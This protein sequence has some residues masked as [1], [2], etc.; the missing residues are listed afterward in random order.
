VGRKGSQDVGG[1][2]IGV[3]GA[4][5]V[6]ECVSGRWASSAQ[7]LG[8]NRAGQGG[9][10]GL[11]ACHA[12]L[13]SLSLG[14]GG[15]V[16]GHLRAVGGSGFTNETVAKGLG[17]E[18]RA[19]ELRIGFGGRAGHRAGGEGSAPVP[20]GQGEGVVGV[21]LLLG[22][23]GLQARQQAGRGAKR[24]ELGRELVKGQNRGVLGEGVVGPGARQRVQRRETDRMLG[25]KQAS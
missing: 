12:A 16:G 24:G 5:G 10:A 17:D 25:L 6:S 20:A 18:P 4:G 9:M 3:G 2:G 11:I 21:A 14:T 1:F 22:G 15:V 8:Q 23:G 7:A 19:Q 13:G